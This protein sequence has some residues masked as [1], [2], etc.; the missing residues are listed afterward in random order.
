MK[1][2]PSYLAISVFFHTTKTE[3]TLKVRAYHSRRI[4]VPR[5]FLVEDINDN[6]AL[7]N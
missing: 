6:K 7:S 5:I 2:R 4:Y 1:T 3:R